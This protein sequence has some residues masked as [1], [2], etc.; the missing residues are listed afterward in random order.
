MAGNRDWLLPFLKA[1]VA[2]ILGL[3][4]SI[5]FFRQSLNKESVLP[6][7]TAGVRFRLYANRRPGLMCQE[8]VGG[9]MQSPAGLYL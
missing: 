2:L 4:G 5:D 1:I 9:C 6:G 8:F 7:A 3:P